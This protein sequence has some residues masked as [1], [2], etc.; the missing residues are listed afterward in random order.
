MTNGSLIHTNLDGI[1]EYSAA[2][3]A[4]SSLAQHNLYLF[5]NDFEGI[6]FNSTA[7]YEI[8]RHFLLSNPANRLLILAQNTSYLANHC[9]RIML[10]LRQFDNRMCIHQTSRQL[11]HITAPFSV[12]DNMHYVRR[13]HFDDPRGIFAQNDPENARA[14]D[15]SYMEMW[16]C[17]RTALSSTTTGL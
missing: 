7:R 14:L 3:D 13:F 5:E 16:E 10:L 4:L 6:G 11:Q 9:P 2:L 12:A 1:V 17:S 8:L 15:L